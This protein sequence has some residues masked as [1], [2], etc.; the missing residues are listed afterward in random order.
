VEFSPRTT[1]SRDVITKII[2][3]ITIRDWVESGQP[4][5]S[6]GATFDSDRETA[7]NYIE[8]VL[9][10]EFDGLV[11]TEKSTSTNPLT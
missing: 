11:F 3:T 9:S 4:L 6:I 8:H 1:R 2:A 5:H 10:R 7:L